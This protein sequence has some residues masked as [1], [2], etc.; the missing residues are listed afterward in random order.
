MKRA[1]AATLQADLFIVIGSSL[2]VFPA[3]S[4]PILVRQNRARLVIINRG[5]TE[6]D[7]TASLV[8]NEEI[9][10]ILSYIVGASS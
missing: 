2:Q 5:S 10:F 3:A 1:E 8:V 4:F 9:T 7:D 6:L